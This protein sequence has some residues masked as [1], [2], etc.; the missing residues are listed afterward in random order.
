MG[1]HL[2]MFSH[3]PTDAQNYNTHVYLAMLKEG[4]QLK[5]AIIGLLI[6]YFATRF[7]G[8]GPQTVEPLQ[9]A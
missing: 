4:D 2:R 9:R 8:E 3:A 7:G 1:Q 6:G 5:G